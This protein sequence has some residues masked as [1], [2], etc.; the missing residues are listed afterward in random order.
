MPL[1][2]SP[3]DDA[4]NGW[5]G[6]INATPLV[7]V[8]LALLI[9]L[10]AA[11]S[12]LNSNASMNLLVSSAQR[13]AAGSNLVV[14]SVDKA[15]NLSLNDTFA[16][17]IQSL[18]SLMEGIAGAN[19]QPKLYIHADAQTHFAHVGQV[20]ATAQGHGFASVNLLTQPAQK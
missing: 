1:Y 17:N 13:Q 8:M 9:I 15:G 6:S 4:E 12:T 18:S 5:I 10:L 14:V 11:S 7:G 19:P 16:P 3:E 20:I 2:S